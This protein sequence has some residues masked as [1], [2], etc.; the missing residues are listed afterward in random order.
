MTTRGPVHISEIAREA[1]A[2]LWDRTCKYRAA[3]GEP[4][5]PEHLNPCNYQPKEHPMNDR[6]ATSPTTRRAPNPHDTAKAVFRPAIVRESADWLQQM[7]GK[8][9]A[10]EP[11]FAAAVDLLNDY[12]TQAAE[13][14]S[15]NLLDHATAAYFRQAADGVER[16]G[17]TGA[18]THLRHVADDYDSGTESPST[19]SF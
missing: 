5:P 19:T 8:E 2:D 17:Y 11:G 15:A 12:A 13:A 7:H 3:H 4:P 10:G 1:L 9:H 6:Y 18:A 16:V 14:P